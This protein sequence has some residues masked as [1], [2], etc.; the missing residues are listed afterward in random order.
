VTEARRKQLTLVACILGTSVVFLDQTVVNV[1]LPALRADLGGSLADQQWVVEAYLLLLASLV[2]VGGSLGDLYGRRRVFAIGVAGFGL[3]SLACAV[4]PSVEVLIGAR[5]LQGAAGALL[6]P[7]SL[8]ILTDVFSGA[9]RG[10]AIG[11]WTAWTSAAIAFGPPLG[12]ALVDAFSWRAIFAINVPLVLVCL[13]LAATAMARTEVAPPR[14]TQ[15]V[16]VVGAALCVVGLGGP[17]YALIQQPLLGWEDPRVWAP[18]RS[19]FVVS[20]ENQR[21]TRFSHELEVGVKCKTNRGWAASQLRIA[22]VL[23]VLLLS[24]TR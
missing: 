4:A 2:L 19:F 14:R 17:V 7:S 18:R 5:A 10:R 16:D 24:S 15:R 1:A 22:G 13:W 21:S 20:S 3:T 12:G 11:L 6:V 9:Q 23:W 8:A